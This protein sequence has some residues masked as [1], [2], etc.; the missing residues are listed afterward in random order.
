MKQFSV[1]VRATITKTMLVIA[2]D[3][4]IANEIANEEFTVECDGDEHYL[5]DVIEIH[6]VAMP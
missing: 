3:A 1:T 4:D 6:E 5:Q 2:D